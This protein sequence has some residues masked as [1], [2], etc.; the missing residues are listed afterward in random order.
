MSA[1]QPNLPDMQIVIRNP[2]GEVEYVCYE[3]ATF[4]LFCT[5]NI[6]LTLSVKK[7]GPGF[8]VTTESSPTCIIAVGQTQTIKFIANLT[9]SVEKITR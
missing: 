7:R 5:G 4:D 6:E 9:F 3:D 8:I 2:A 1:D